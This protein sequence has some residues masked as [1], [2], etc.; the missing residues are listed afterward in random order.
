MAP[1]VPTLLLRSIQLSILPCPSYARTAFRLPFSQCVLLSLSSFVSHRRRRASPFITWVC[2]PMAMGVCAAERIVVASRRLPSAATACV[3]LCVSGLV[4]CLFIRCVFAPPLCPDL[5]S[6]RP[7]RIPSTRHRPFA[8]A[9]ARWKM[10][11]TRVVHLSWFCLLLSLLQAISTSLLQNFNVNNRLQ[12]AC[13][14]ESVRHGPTFV[15]KLF[16]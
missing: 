9:V 14:V 4:L 7:S 3:C 11:T 15:D 8:F 13:S 6:G 12:R 2:S 5:F 16:T 1:Y 10:D